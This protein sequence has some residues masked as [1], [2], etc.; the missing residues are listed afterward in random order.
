MIIND[1][2][3][4]VWTKGAGLVRE[5]GKTVNNTDARRG[6]NTPQLIGQYF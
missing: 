4:L 5:D 3:K 6:L 1:L 2:T